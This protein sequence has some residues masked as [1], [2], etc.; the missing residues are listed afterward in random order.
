MRPVRSLRR[1]LGWPALA[2]AVLLAASAAVALQVPDSVP[3][4]APP[5]AASPPAPP[6]AAART[7]A[8]LAQAERLGVAVARTEQRD[9]GGADAGLQLLTP[10]R[11]GYAALR[12]FAETSLAADPHLALESVRLHRSS[13]DAAALEAEFVWWLAGAGR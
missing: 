11:G 3:V 4:K 2:G 1:A 13:D 5:R 10:A 8:L 12:G 6:S 9:R 7:A